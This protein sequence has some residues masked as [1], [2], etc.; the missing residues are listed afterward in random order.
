MPDQEH[1]GLPGDHE[2]RGEG[3][4]SSLPLV[5]DKVH[6]HLRSNPASLPIALDTDE[7]ITR[8]NG[9]SNKILAW[10]LV[11]RDIAWFWE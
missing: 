3:D 1:V 5:G 2:R 7:Q 9:V 11:R 6:F 8:R 4:G 10:V